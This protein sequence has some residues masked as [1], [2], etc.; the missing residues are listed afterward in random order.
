[1]SNIGLIPS[2]NSSGQEREETSR[3][4]DIKPKKKHFKSRTNHTF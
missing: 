4:K 3:E 2:A 1:M